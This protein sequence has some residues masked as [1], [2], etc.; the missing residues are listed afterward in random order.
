MIMNAKKIK[1]LRKK[2]SQKGYYEKR[3]NI[4]AEKCRKWN[5]FNRWECNSFFVG[6]EKAER[7]QYIYD[8]KGMRDIRKC[9]Y[10][11][12]KVKKEE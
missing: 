10:Y 1:R 3:W 12:R 2:I 6:F 5:S 8:T 9:D 11:R 7:N 4:Y